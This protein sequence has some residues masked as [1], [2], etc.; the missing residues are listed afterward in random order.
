[1]PTG[2]LGPGLS[3]GYQSHSQWFCSITRFFADIDVNKVHGGPPLS[4]FWAKVSPV[5]F[6]LNVLWFEGLLWVAWPSADEANELY[7]SGDSPKVLHNIVFECIW[8][9]WKTGFGSGRN[10]ASSMCFLDNPWRHLMLPTGG[11]L[12]TT[13]PVGHLPG[14]LW[15]WWC[16][17]IEQIHTKSD[18]FNMPINQMTKCLL[19][20]HSCVSWFLELTC[21]KQET[22]PRIITLKFQWCKGAGCVVSTA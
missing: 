11:D 13:V 9:T 21:F 5:A 4:T 14:C 18:D 16:L 3:L 2:W 22:H 10:F 7:S 12:A 6:F 1:M 17:T 20:S 15:G 8:K 19:L